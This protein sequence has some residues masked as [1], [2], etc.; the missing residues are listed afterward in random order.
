MGNEPAQGAMGEEGKR[1]RLAPMMVG[2]LSTPDPDGGSNH[3]PFAMLL[4][5]DVDAVPGFREVVARQEAGEEFDVAARWAAAM[6]DE[7]N[8]PPHAV[9][10][11]YLP[12]FDLGIAIYIDVDEYP[13]SI[14]AALRTGR[15]AIVDPPTSA[16]LQQADDVAAALDEVRAFSVQP[17]DPAP[18]VGVLQQ[19]FDFPRERYEPIRET[20]T[21]ETSAEVANAFLEGGTIVAGA[22]VFVRGDAPSSIILVDPG[23]GSLRA[24]LADDAKV[25]GRW[26]VMAAGE[27]SVVAFDAVADGAPLG[28][29]LIA[30]PPDELV[31]VGSNGAH[32]VSVLTALPSDDQDEA[33]RLWKAGIHAWVPH[34]ESLRALR[35]EREKSSSSR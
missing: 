18:L 12:E 32:G 20:L 17:P 29:W 10:D 13:N 35:L 5:V 27:H 31:R 26:G 3:P 15:V 14:Q 34:V 8:H 1:H 16:R 25:E 23:S 19:R 24:E 22:G 7:G 9:L 6:D 4:T 21:P 28:R 11:F 30:D 33:N 2:S